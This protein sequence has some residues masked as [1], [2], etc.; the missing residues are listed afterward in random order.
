MKF[1]TIISSILVLWS[2]IS[3]GQSLIDFK[4]NL[5]KVRIENF[6]IKAS[7]CGV[8]INTSLYKA[9]IIR[10]YGE[11]EMVLL[12]FQCAETMRYLSSE[13]ELYVEKYIPKP[14]DV[15]DFTD[16]EAMDKNVLPKYRVV[17]V[18]TGVLIEN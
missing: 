10:S 1:K 13:L 15:F 3:I 7:D 4:S 12:Y 16:L 5:V 14:E 18:K 17:S 9:R 6:H 11:G 8:A 2:F